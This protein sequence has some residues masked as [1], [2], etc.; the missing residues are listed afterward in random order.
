MGL[1]TI[2]GNISTMDSEE[3]KRIKDKNKNFLYARAVHVNHMIQHH[4]HENSEHQRVVD[5]Y[6]FMVDRGREM[7]PLELNSTKMIR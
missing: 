1:P 3:L 4:M 5:E 7:I 6:Q 2:D